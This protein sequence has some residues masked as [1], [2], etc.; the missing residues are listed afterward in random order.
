LGI[1]AE[2]VVTL[3]PLPVSGAAEEL[4]VE[5]A[6][7]AD[8]RFELVGDSAERVL[9]L[10]T[11]LDGLPLAIELAAARV[12][13]LSPAGIADRVAEDLSSLASRDPTVESRRRTLDA[14][15][16]WSFEQLSTTAQQVLCELSVVPV[17]FELVLAAAVVDDDISEPALED[18]IVELADNSLVSRRP[19][20][21]FV[22]YAMLNT[23]RT[24]GQGK[25]RR[26][27]S[28]R[29][30]RDRFIRRWTDVTAAGVIPRDAG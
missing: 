22:R 11:A 3:E 28:Y 23:I 20:P 7:A 19:H 26:S 17:P 2:S 1:P 5:R 15:I 29:R 13:A 16:G 18:A 14:V 6:R 25:L 24:Y 4:F 8:D 30:V 9:E 10:C 21:K 27:G 12:R